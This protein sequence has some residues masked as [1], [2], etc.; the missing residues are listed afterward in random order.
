[1]EI[2][3]NLPVMSPGLHRDS[4]LSWCERIDQGFY[5]SL[6][7]GERIAFYNPEVL[8]TLAAAAATT[9]RVKLVSNVIVPMLHH[10]VM[11]AKQL[12]TLDTLSSGRLVVGLGVGGREQDYQAVDAPMGRRLRRLADAVAAMRRVW[13]QEPVVP[14]AL[15]VGPAPSRAT[16]PTLLAGSLSPD[17]IAVSSRW[18]D[19]LTGFAFGPSEMEMKM[20]LDA[21]RK[22][23]E[24][25]G[26]PKPW[27]AT[28][29]W[30]ALGDDARAQLD[31]YLDR[32]LNFMAP[33]ARDSVKAICSVT[34]AERLREA[35]QKARDLGAD[36]VLLVPTT[37]DPDDVHRV[38][39]ILA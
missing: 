22:A 15:P 24:G 38:A 14:E 1:M 34:S 2:G 28:G 8:T 21:A 36:E 20:Q 3:I 30:Y 39:D 27:L 33:I 32:Y 9:S 35:V 25:R 29:F 10:P 26:R 7:V 16:G 6:A 12:A 18:A 23:W 5:S 11:L 37:A 17:A 19:G 13:S 4:L 31:A